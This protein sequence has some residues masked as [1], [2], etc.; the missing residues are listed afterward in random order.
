MAGHRHRY[1]Y[2]SR[3][4]NTK[5]RILLVLRRVK[6]S[7]NCLIDVSVLNSGSPACIGSWRHT[8]G[9]KTRSE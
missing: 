6:D 4:H 1:T 8:G 2:T 9:G 7:E 3:P 5:S